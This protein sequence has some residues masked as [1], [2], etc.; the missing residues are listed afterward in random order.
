MQMY[1]APDLPDALVERYERDGFFI[2]PAALDEQECD[3]LKA[4]AVDLLAEDRKSVLVAVSGMSER[5]RELSE[6]RRVLDR[7]EPL[8]PGGVTFK[9][10]KFVYKNGRQRFATP[11]HTDMLY[12]PNQRP[13]LSVWI[14]LDDV[15]AEN[16]TLTVI[17]GSH[18]REWD[19]VEVDGSD[20]SSG[21]FRKR[22]D[23]ATI[24]TDEAVVCEIPRGSLVVFSDALLHASTPATSGADRYAIISTYHETRTPDPEPFGPVTKVLSAT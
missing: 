6:D 17:P 12:W 20:S 22:S 4:I 10:D 1:N 7:I 18:R 14:P 13:K 19:V 16:G 9:S 21:E 3:D 23:I 5:Y 11:W 8:M 2:V 15:S 24:P